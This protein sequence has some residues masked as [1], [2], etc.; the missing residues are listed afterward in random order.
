MHFPPCE[1]AS[2]HHAN[3]Q[4]FLKFVLWLT[5]WHTCVCKCSRFSIWWVLGSTCL[6]K[7]N[8]F[9]VLF[10]SGWSPFTKGLFAR[11]RNP[12]ITLQIR[13]EPCRF[14]MGGWISKFKIL[15]I[16]PLDVVADYIHAKWYHDEDLLRRQ[17]K[18][19]SKS[20]GRKLNPAKMHQ[21]PQGEV[22]TYMHGL[23]IVLKGAPKGGGLFVKV[24][25]GIWDLDWSFGQKIS[26]QQVYMF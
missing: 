21:H 16:S 3:T 24:Y 18:Y 26:D 17:E 14:V 2:V 8:L 6:H 19:M 11:Q 12:D 5:C 7:S 4:R 1:I 15:K 23:G 9:A 22:F 25:L 10:K 20:M 13:R